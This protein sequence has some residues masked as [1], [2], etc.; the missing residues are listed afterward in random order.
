MR[1]YKNDTGVPDWHDVNA[2]P[3]PDAPNGQW[4]W[5]FLRRRE[6][7]REAWRAAYDAGQAHYDEMDR[8]AGVWG[9]GVSREDYREVLPFPDDRFPITLMR[10]PS[11]RYRPTP[12][13]FRQEGGAYH[14]M[15]AESEIVRVRMESPHACA[16]LFD[17]SKPL[18]PQLAKAGKYLEVVQAEL[19]GTV[20]APRHHRRLWPKYLRVLDARDA[21]ETFESIFEHIELTGLSVAEFDARADRQNWAASG[22]Q[23][24]EQARD[25]MFKITA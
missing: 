16:Y 4:R 15:D 22:R 25:L 17:L 6:D 9:P 12:G 7:Y 10:A 19:H 14:R 24:W 18:A 21:G 8:H 13:L 3:E 1:D 23:L 20:K 11:W 2:Y 5:E